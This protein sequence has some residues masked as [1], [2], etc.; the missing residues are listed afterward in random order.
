MKNLLPILFRP[1]ETMKAILAHRDRMVVP[2]VLLAILSG[3][4]KD[5]RLSGARQ[6]VKT[7][8]SPTVW[9]I[10]T[11]VFL[12]VIPLLVAFFYLLAW[13]AVWVGR[14]FEGRA[15]TRAVRSALAWGGAPVIW[16]LLYRIP[17]AIFVQ[18]AETSEAK[19]RAGNWAFNPQQLSGG[20]GL[21]LAIAMLNLVVLIWYLICASNT[22]AE[23]FDFSGWRGF[24]TLLLTW[25][26]PLVV[27]LAAVLAKVF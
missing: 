8:P 25:L 2:L 4:I 7:L 10:V 16:A 27:L 12:C 23:A 18:G 21:A 11:A 24:A 13:I 14:L 3:G 1:R 26:S 22:L 15:T 9:L 6:A 20:C 17:V 19:I 5:V